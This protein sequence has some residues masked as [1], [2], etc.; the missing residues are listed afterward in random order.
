M[1]V[2][3]DCGSC[4]INGLGQVKVFRT[5]ESAIETYDAMV[6]DGKDMESFKVREVYI[7]D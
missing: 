2:I 1:Y 6:A 5:I 3:T 7:A 4:V